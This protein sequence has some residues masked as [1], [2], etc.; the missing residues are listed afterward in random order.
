MSRVAPNRLVNHR[1][2][3]QTST[4]Q[5]RGLSPII[6]CIVL[7][8]VTVCLA[9]IL[10]I[11]VS[12]VAITTPVPAVSFDVHA[13]GDE[14]TLTLEHTAGDDIDVTDLSVSVAINETE[15]EYQPPVPFVGADG[16]R[17]S[18][19]G[20]FNLRS[21]TIWQSGER[22][23]VTIAET[24]EPLLESGDVVRVTLTVEGQQIGERETIAV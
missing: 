15:L 8:V 2:R 13:D 4:R 16:F 17:G 12:G 21:D 10:V 22:A 11:A 6:G 7:L 24:N 1:V 18:P 23:S 5:C 20:P 9:S 19:S 3:N 14:G